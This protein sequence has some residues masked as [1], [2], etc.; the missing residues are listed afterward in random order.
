VNYK[1]LNQFLKRF[2]TVRALGKIVRVISDELVLVNE[3]RVDLVKKHGEEDATTKA[4]NVK[5]ESLDA[6]YKDFSDILNTEVELDITPLPAKAL[7]HPNVLIST[8]EYYL[9][10]KFIEA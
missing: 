7:E 9:I 5:K 8:K 2:A 1:T 4:F 3:K 6:F 10:E